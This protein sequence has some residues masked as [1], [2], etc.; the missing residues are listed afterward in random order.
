MVIPTASFAETDTT[1]NT[2]ASE[3]VT[4]EEATDETYEET[5]EMEEDEFEDLDVETAPSEPPSQFG[6]WFRGLKENLT[7]ALTFDPV[8][9]AEKQ[10]KFAEERMQLAELMANSTIPAV[11]EKAQNMVDRASAFMEKVEAH[12]AKW[13]NAS[14][15]DRVKKL[16]RNAATFE[17][18][19]EQRLDRIEAFL[20]EGEL[21]KFHA[22]RD[23]SVERSKR[24]LNAINNENVP[25]E[26]RAHLQSIKDRIETRADEREALK[27]RRQ[28]LLDE[29]K[30]G[31]VEAR[32][33]L[34]N[35]FKDA[36]AKSKA[37]FEKWNEKKEEIRKLKIDAAA[38]DEDAKAKLHD[39][40]KKGQE[41]KANIKAKKEAVKEKVEAKKQDLKEKAADGD[42]DAKAKLKTLKKAEDKLEALK[43]K[44]DKKLEKKAEKKAM[45]EEK[46]PLPKKSY[47]Y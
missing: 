35:F 2:A 7:V 18:R 37:R 27:S 46:K 29:A 47:G 14:K 20:P 5:E 9:K 32:E 30:E 15:K 6:L 26:V 19:N 12:K 31:G 40:K 41:L 23:K 43:K 11:R 24:L 42:E 44:V 22:L 45:K 36:K 28:K 38:G 13:E 33:R 16:L 25:E 1:E 10:M 17:L 8:R 34:Q 39:A 21:E 4:E 3:V